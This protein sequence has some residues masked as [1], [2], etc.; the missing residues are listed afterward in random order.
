MLS[1]II[2]QQLKFL[3][4]F[5]HL[6]ALE[7]VKTIDGGAANTPKEYRPLSLLVEPFHIT[8]VVRTY[9]DCPTELTQWATSAMS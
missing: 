1:Y 2:I 3:Q 4:A 7:L 6:Q 9:P 8:E 5:E